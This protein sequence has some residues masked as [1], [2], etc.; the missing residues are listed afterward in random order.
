MHQAPDA[1]TQ[2]E[3]CVIDLMA[4]M[5]VHAAV[6]CLLLR[7]GVEYM[8]KHRVMS[9][10]ID[11]LKEVG[12]VQI[13]QKDVNGSLISLADNL[14]NLA[15]HSNNSK[16]WEKIT[17]AFSVDTRETRNGNRQ[18]Q[19]LKTFPAFISLQA[20]AASVLQLEEIISDYHPGL[21]LQH[22]LGLGAED[23]RHRYLVLKAIY[24][25][26]V[27]QGTKDQLLQKLYQIG[28]EDIM[29]QHLYQLMNGVFI[30]DLYTRDG[31]FWFDV[32]NRPRFKM[33]QT[34]FQTVNDFSTSLPDAVRAR[35]ELLRDYQRDTSR[36]LSLYKSARE[37]SG[38]TIK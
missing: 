15:P 1:L 12:R 20:L 37:K 32:I 17:G 14:G 35:S 9:A 34:L 21:S 29:G 33:F 30:E 6:F 25:T 24:Y 27:S 7:P 31:E 5:P 36:L 10:V 2:N 26:S 19:G 3:G 22:L 13:P 16:E 23:S 38:N 11:P 18:I 8:N 4:G 28:P